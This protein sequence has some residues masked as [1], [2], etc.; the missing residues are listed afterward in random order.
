MTKVIENTN[1]MK[2]PEDWKPIPGY[3]G[4]YEVSNWGRVRSFKWNSDGRILSPGKNNM[5]YY[6]VYLCKDG[7]A[8]GHTI[9]RLVAQAFIQNPSNF[10]VVNHKDECKENNCVD[11]LEWCT[12]K[13]NISYGTGLQRMAEK[14]SKPVVQLD[15]NGNFVAEYKSTQE[16][17]RVTGINHGN[18]C[19]CCNHKSYKSAGG[20]IW[21]YK[22]EYAAT[23][24]DQ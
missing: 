13:Y 15:K 3:E 5:G 16:A 12:Q 19:C 14:I 8:K 9:H 2:Q 18:I 22:D 1:S 10:P 4:L 23:Q 24:H 6:F 21:I 20:F 7:K 17:S 11:N